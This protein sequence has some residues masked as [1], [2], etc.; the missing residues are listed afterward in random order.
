MG[1]AACGFTRGGRDGA[2][3]CGYCGP[4]QGVGPGAVPEGESRG[5]G[6]RRRPGPTVVARGRRTPPICV[7]GAA[8]S[9]SRR[10]CA[11]SHDTWAT[12]WSPAVNAGATALW[13]NATPEP[14]PTTGCA[15]RQWRDDRCGR[16]GDGTAFS[17]TTASSPS[18][19]A[20]GP[21]VGRRGR[22]GGP[23][24]DQ[25]PNAEDRRGTAARAPPVRGGSADR[26][27]RGSSRASSVPQARPGRCGRRA[28][29]ARRSHGSGRRP[30]HS[31]SAVREPDESG[32]GRR[33]SQSPIAATTTTESTRSATMACSPPGGRGRR[34]IPRSGGG[35][36]G[37]SPGPGERWVRQER[38]EQHPP[39]GRPAGRAPARNGCDGPKRA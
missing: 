18:G 30:G 39:G 33:L 31:H 8:R 21:G 38:A 6:C 14:G 13:T 23:H 32:G 16:G 24:A 36:C 10:R 9:S 28:W 22:G 12:G 2:P 34:R 15:R 19:E 26:G 5:G 7:R 29:T 27:A 25:P 11:V 3:A 1:S 37:T 35:C 20:P 4:V 17:R